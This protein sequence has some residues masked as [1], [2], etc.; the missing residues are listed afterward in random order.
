METSTSEAKAPGTETI[1]IQKDHGIQEVGIFHVLPQV[2]NT[3]LLW[4]WEKYQKN[5]IPR[6]LI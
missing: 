6:I 3:D 4:N 2:Y 5:P 1:N